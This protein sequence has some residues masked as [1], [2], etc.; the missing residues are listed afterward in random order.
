MS[1]EKI[2]KAVNDYK[3]IRNTLTD[4]IL[5]GNKTLKELYKEYLT[6]TIPEDATYL[7][8]RKLAC[9][10]MY[11]YQMAMAGY[12]SSNARFTALKETYEIGFREYY[13]SLVAE[14]S[15]TN[16]KIPAA[17]YLEAMSRSATDELK[18]A[19]LVAE[20]ERNYWK[21]IITHLGC[22]RK[23]LEIVN[24]S[25]ALELKNIPGPRDP[26]DVSSILDKNNN[27]FPE[28]NEND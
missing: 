16:S 18:S 9:K 4:K 23:T 14:A 10:L 19:V 26:E 20:V 8:V 3:I 21:D 28:E 27:F 6:L 25:S 1:I 12:S 17:S 7:E 11:L 24:M 15:R 22:M 2:E 5:I 13:Q